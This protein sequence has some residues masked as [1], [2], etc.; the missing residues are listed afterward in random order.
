MEH[1]SMRIKDQSVLRLFWHPCERTMDQHLQSLYLVKFCFIYKDSSRQ[2]QACKNLEYSTNEP[3]YKNYML[4][5]SQKHGINEE[6]T[7]KGTVMKGLLTSL[8]SNL[9][10]AQD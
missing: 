7:Y 9:I 8:E 4:K 2:S 3:Y 5:F 6:L 1:L 10:H